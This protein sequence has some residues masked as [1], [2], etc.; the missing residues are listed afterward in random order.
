MCAVDLRTRHVVQ[1]TELVWWVI[2]NVKEQ[3]CGLMSASYSETTPKSMING[4]LDRRTSYLRIMGLVSRRDGLRE[5]D[6][7]F[8][9]D[10]EPHNLG[11]SCCRVLAAEFMIYEI[12][13]G[14]DSI[15]KMLHEGSQR[16]GAST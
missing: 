4:F 1:Q 8:P 7:R 14:I 6:L 12:A 10:C 2:I 13:H 5:D 15:V 9:D 16:F 3:Q 11:P